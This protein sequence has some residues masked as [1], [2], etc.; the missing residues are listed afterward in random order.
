[1]KQ[2]TSF[3]PERQERWKHKGR[4]YSI[5]DLVVEPLEANGKRGY[6]GSKFSELMAE[7]Y[8]DYHY[9]LAELLPKGGGHCVAALC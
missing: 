5:V 7:N 8:G 2:L 1:M 3:D 4:E 6:P 9:E